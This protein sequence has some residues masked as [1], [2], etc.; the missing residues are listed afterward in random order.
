M[1]KYYKC[2]KCGKKFTYFGDLINHLNKY[3]SHKKRLIKDKA[4]YLGKRNKEYIKRDKKIQKR[5]KKGKNIGW[6]W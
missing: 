1:V 5:I 6:G 3:P 2:L 4:K